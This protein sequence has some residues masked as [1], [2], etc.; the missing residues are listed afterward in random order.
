V[1]CNSICRTCDTNARKCTSCD[2]KSP[3][4]Y[5]LKDTWSCVG[6]CPNTHYLVNFACIPCAEECNTCSGSGLNCTSCSPLKTTRLLSSI[7]RCVENCSP[8]E[9]EQDQRCVKCM[10]PCRECVSSPT[11]CT[12]CLSGV[13]ANGVCIGNCPP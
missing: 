4:P 6:V 5:F 3:Y 8:G 9:V 13:L 12:S 1:R 11:F 7:N 10:A 2:A